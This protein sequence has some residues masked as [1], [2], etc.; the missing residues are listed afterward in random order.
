MGFLF[1][2]T[3]TF[4]AILSAYS[5]S[6]VIAGGRSVVDRAILTL[7]VS[8]ATVLVVV[9]S[10]GLLGL[11][12]ALPVGITA[13]LLHLAILAWS[14]SRVGLIELKR[15]C[16]RD[17]LAPFRLLR[18]LYHEQELAGWG[19]VVAICAILVSLIHIFNFPTW[20]WDCVWYHKAMTNYLLQDG[21]LT[22]VPTHI[23]YINAYPQNTEL[24]SAW[25][26][27]FPH[28]TKFDDGSMVPTALLGALAVSA[29]CRRAKAT[30]ALS[31][32][33]GAM[34]IALPAVALEIHTTHA[35]VSAGAFFI[36]AYYFATQRPF[37][38]VAQFGTLLA[39]GLYAGTKS[40][41]LFHAALAAP[42]LL[43]C[44]GRRFFFPGSAT[45]RR[46][47]AELAGTLAL[48]FGVGGF[49]YCRNFALYRNPV[50][51]VRVKIPVLGWEL[52]GTT[53]SPPEIGLSPPF[54][55][56]P[57]AFETMVRHWFLRSQ[58]Y[59]PDVR[60]GAF[61]LLFPYCLLPALLIVCVSLPFGRDRFDRFS[62]IVFACLTV[63]VPAAWWGRFTLGLPAAGLVA[64]AIVHRQLASRYL[65]VV[66]SAVAAFLCVSSYAHAVPG[67]QVFPVLSVGRNASEQNQAL[68]RARLGWLWPLAAAHLR[69]TEL[70]QGDVV[71]YDS[72]ATFLGEYWT[73]DVRNKLVYVP[74]T[75]NDSQYIEALHAA[76]PK[77]IGVQAESAAERIL[78]ARPLHFQ[79]LFTAR[80]TSERLYRVLRE[81]Y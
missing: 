67:Y 6:I 13:A 76:H 21:K 54:F 56:A 46:I 11:F 32:S 53:H 62:L 65:Q 15:H 64:L 80:L 38:S 48:A 74:H 40:T 4:L 35:D 58:N 7:I 68:L 60:E 19:L 20:S 51:P 43:F 70:R 63:A 77:W 17:L 22:W 61:G 30:P 27:V 33:L 69:D 73:D 45:R 71:T 50:W 3:E 9:Y 14:A 59:F 37:D 16:A 81:D 78:R 1:L 31:A 55:G 2:A 25:N 44:I 34:W 79:Y 42:Y 66:V 10:C 23:S 26:S 47:A 41:G 75:G 8:L 39:L 5:F 28:H 18:N 36:A 52:P 57:G 49:S 29:L 12:S 24:I 72:G